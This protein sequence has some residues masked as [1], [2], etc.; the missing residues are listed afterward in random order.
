MQLSVFFRQSLSLYE[1]LN[2]VVTG[3]FT[4]WRVSRG[5]GTTEVSLLLCEFP[6][7]GRR[8]TGEGKP[9]GTTREVSHRFVVHFR[10]FLKGVLGFPKPSGSVSDMHTNLKVFDERCSSSLKRKITKNIKS[11]RRSRNQE[12]YAH[13]LSIPVFPR[14][15]RKSVTVLDSGFSLAPTLVCTG[16]D[17]AG[18]SFQ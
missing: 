3:V 7:D 11:R 17:D 2:V 13:S 4:V 10:V 6:Q 15:F 8:G 9:E 18:K 5:K 16:C 1:Y 12:R 14:G